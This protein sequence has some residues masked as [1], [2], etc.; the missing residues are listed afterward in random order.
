[1]A[2]LKNFSKTDIQHYFFMIIL[3]LI[4]YLVVDYVVKG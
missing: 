2:K 4:L 1:M 3:L